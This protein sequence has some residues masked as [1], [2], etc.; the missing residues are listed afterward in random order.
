LGACRNLARCRGIADESAPTFAD[1]SAPTFADESAPTVADEGFP[2]K[3]I[4]SVSQTALLPRLLDMDERKDTADV[5]W[6][7]LLAALDQ[8]PTDA[9]VA[10]LLS[11]VF[12]MRVDDVAVLLR[13]DVRHCRELVEEARSHIQSVRYGQNERGDKA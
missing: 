12:D 2:Q 11:E 5:V 4:G 8:L 1:E 3:S 7:G 6:T 10:F 13:R 9:R